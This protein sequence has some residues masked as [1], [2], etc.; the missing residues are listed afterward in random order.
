ME[1]HC[2]YCRHRVSLPKHGHCPHCGCEVAMLGTILH[3][4]HDSLQLGLLALYDGRYAE[5]CDLAE[6]AWG[7]KRCREA[8]AIGLMAATALSD[9]IEISRWLR[10][11]RRPLEGTP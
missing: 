2:P 11:R 9:P 10:R 5:A 3:A 6:E 4:T 1:V 8:T 7:L